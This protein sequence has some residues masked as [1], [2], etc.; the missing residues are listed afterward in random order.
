MPLRLAVEG[1]SVSYGRLRALD[2]VDLVV[3]EGRVVALL[4]PNGAGKSTLLR[5]IAGLVP[6][7]AGHIRL[8]GELLDLLPAHQ[9][10]ARG[11]ALIPEGRGIFP[12]LTVADNLAVALGGSG[13]AVQRV[14]EFFPILGQRMSQLA[15]TLSGGE[16]QMLALARA[17]ASA[18]GATA[19]GRTPAEATA[20][21]STPG[22]PG[23]RT[24]GGRTPGG[25]T[26]PLLLADELS[27]GLAPILVATIGDTLHRLHVDHGR[28]ILLVEQ[29]ATMA[30]RLADI[31]Y[32][33]DRGQVAWVGDPDEL[34]ASRVLVESYLG[35]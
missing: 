3:P 18:D 14:V 19:G 23:G 1:V 27:L 29:Y 16:Q 17:V 33:L 26:A 8:R 6:A 35:S 21:G 10:S 5:T 28:T 31:V 25:S 13:A 2:A 20:G 4:G 24:P 30:L 32:I 34:R 11:I 9:R 7:E 15:G 22:T 12:S